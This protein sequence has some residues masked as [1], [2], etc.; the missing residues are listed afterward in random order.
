[1]KKTLF[2]LTAI[3]CLTVNPVFAKPATQTNPCISQA[4]L[5]MH[6]FGYELNLASCHLHD[7][8]MEA[9]VEYLQSHSAWRLNLDNNHIGVEGIR[10]LVNN[11]KVQSNITEISLTDNHIGD[12]GVSKLSSRM[13]NLRTLYVE[14]NLITDAGANLLARNNH[15]ERLSIGRNPISIES[16]EQLAKNPNFTV[17]GLRQLNLSDATAI[18]LARSQSFETDMIMLK[19]NCAKHR[20]S[21]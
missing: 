2:Y 13:H 16:V 10:I 12:S 15:L 6:D 3:A 19:I 4:G 14:N 11:E 5:Q 18:L 1:M 8:D 9:V 17:L 21:C 20:T 7:S